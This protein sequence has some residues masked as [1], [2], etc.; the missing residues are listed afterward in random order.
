MDPIDWPETVRSFRERGFAK[1]FAKIEST[2]LADLKTEV[3]RLQRSLNAGQSDS[4]IVSFI[5][6]PTGRG[7][8]INNL[9]CISEVFREVTTRAE[10]LTEVAEITGAK[11]LRIWRDQ[12]LVKPTGVTG[13]VKWHQDAFWWQVLSPANQITAWFSLDDVSSDNGCMAMVEGSHLWGLQTERIHSLN[14]GD[15]L[16]CDDTQLHDRFRDCELGSGEIHY[17]HC[18]T[19]HGSHANRSPNIRIAYAIHFLVDDTI[20]TRFDHPIKNL[21]TL[22]ARGYISGPLFPQV[23]PLQTETA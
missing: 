4:T 17:H 2:A 21:I 19:W 23:W 12:L 16:N 7:L 15:V 18:L 9:W 8:K 20:V 5:D 10:L 3:Q 22:D 11:T 13:T 1:G 14:H 6:G